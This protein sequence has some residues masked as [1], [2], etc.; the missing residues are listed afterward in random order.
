MK[1]AIKYP[2]V[3]VAD[4]IL[5]DLRD[6]DGADEPRGVSEYEITNK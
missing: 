6:V 5:G 1:S 2:L 3:T 4:A